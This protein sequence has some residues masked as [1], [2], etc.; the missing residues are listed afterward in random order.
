MMIP[1]L[2]LVQYVPYQGTVQQLHVRVPGTGYPRAW[3]LPVIDLA[4]AQPEV[5]LSVRRP[6]CMN[7]LTS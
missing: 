7:L 4:R 3:S 1:E 6:T 5:V 2:Y